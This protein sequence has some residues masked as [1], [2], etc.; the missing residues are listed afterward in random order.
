MDHTA[1]I[2]QLECNFQSQ[3]LDGYTC[4][5]R[6]ILQIT[7]LTELKKCLQEGGQ[8]KQMKNKYFKFRCFHDRYGDLNMGQ[9]SM[10]KIRPHYY[11][12]YDRSIRRTLK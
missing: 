2:N 7:S 12:E 11:T 3:K 9:I 5:D 10:T 6:K 1:L 4:T 8:Q